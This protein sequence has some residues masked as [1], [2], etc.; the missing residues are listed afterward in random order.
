MNFTVDKYGWGQ[1]GPFPAV[2]GSLQAS[3]QG[4]A[5]SFAVSEPELRAHHFYYNEMVCEDSCVEFFFRAYPD[6]PRYLNIEI[7]PLGTVHMGIGTGRSP[8][9]VKVDPALIAAIEV[10]TTV[11]R[12]GVNPHWTLEY[13]LPYPLIAEIYGREPMKNVIKANFYKCGDLQSHPHWG[14]WRPIDTPAPDF[15]R[16]E[17]FGEI[18]L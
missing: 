6:D 16:P 11:R 8:K 1:T 4:L 13:T 14:S 17:F 5:I 9:R 2:T 18:V 10:K 3:S 12:G 15:H 7:N